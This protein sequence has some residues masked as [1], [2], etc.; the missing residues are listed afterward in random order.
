MWFVFVALIWYL[1]INTVI[2]IWICVYVY[3]GHFQI[4]YTEL[5]CNNTES[6]KLLVLCYLSQKTM[7]NFIH[8]YSQV[9]SVV[10]LCHMADV[11]SVSDFIPNRMNHVCI[12]GCNCF[13]YLC[14]YFFQT[15]RKRWNTNFVFNVSPH[16]KIQGC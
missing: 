3:K 4:S 9:F 10:C 6:R 13:C 1:G 8:R 15:C 14:P 12:C 7:L 5:R 11:P 2:C 16:R